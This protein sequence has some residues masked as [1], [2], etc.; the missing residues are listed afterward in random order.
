MKKKNQMH[1]IYSLHIFTVF[2]LHV[3]VLHYLQGELNAISFRAHVTQLLATVIATV[4]GKGKV[5][6]RTGH[7][8]PE[9]G[10]DV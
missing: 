6:P 2:L 7:E 8:G 9:G 10:V 1:N 4:K 3:S 5:H